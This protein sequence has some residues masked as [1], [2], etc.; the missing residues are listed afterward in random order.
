M[1]KIEVPYLVVSAEAGL[2]KVSVRLDQLKR[3]QIEKISW[4]A[5][6][7]KPTVS[8]AIAHNDDNIL[9]KY[10]ISEKWIRALYRNTHDPV[11]RDSCVEFFISFDNNDEYYNLE[12]NCIGTCMLGFGKGK[13]SRKLIAEEVVQNIKR[14]SVINVTNVGNTTITNW[15]LTL[16]IPREVFIYH[17]ISTLKNRHCRA[18]LFKC[19]DELPEPHFLSWQ[20]IESD[21]PDFHQ[22]EFFGPIHFSGNDILI[23]DKLAI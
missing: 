16:I 12:F 20:R 15:E 5:Y 14:Q 19:G 1:E 10:F 6:S 22:P 7:Y 21:F 18:N 13:G 23:T 2:Q 17:P 8:F 9:L 4:P 11:F 3:Y